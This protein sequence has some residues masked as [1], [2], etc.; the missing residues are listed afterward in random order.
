MFLQRIGQAFVLAKRPVGAHLL[1]VQHVKLR[2]VP[3]F[4]L[5][6]YIGKLARQP[7]IEIVNPVHA[8]ADI[9]KPVSIGHEYRCA[10]RVCGRGQLPRLTRRQVTSPDI[11]FLDPG[12]PGPVTVI[13]AAGVR[14][15]GQAPRVGLLNLPAVYC[16]AVP[17]TD[18]FAASFLAIEHRL[19]GIAPVR[20]FRPVADP[21]GVRHDLF[22]G[23]PGD[24]CTAGKQGHRDQQCKTCFHHSL[25]LRPNRAA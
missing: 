16:N 23:G 17:V 9:G 12:N 1:L 13:N 4:F 10:C 2:V 7:G 6:L 24:R 14:A 15:C 18:A 21:V 22:E 3:R 25:R 5:Q 19:A 20:S 8:S 11:A